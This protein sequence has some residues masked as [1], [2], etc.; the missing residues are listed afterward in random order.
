MFYCVALRKQAYSYVMDLLSCGFQP[1]NVASPE[2]M[3]FSSGNSHKTVFVEG[4]NIF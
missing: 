4:L 1:K 3:E 2:K